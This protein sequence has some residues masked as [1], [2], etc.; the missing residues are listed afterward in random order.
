[1]A[2]DIDGQM[3]VL[4]SSHVIH[5]NQL[6][7]ERN[8]KHSFLGREGQ[9][10]FISIHH[11]K[12]FQIGTE[13]Q[14]VFGPKL[15]A[16]DNTDRNNETRDD[17]ESASTQDDSESDNS[18]DDSESASPQDDSESDNPQDNNES[19]SPRNDRNAEGNHQNKLSYNIDITALK[20]SPAALKTITEPCGCA[21]DQ[22]PIIFKGQDWDLKATEVQKFG[23]ASGVTCGRIVAAQ[24]AYRLPRATQRQFA[25]NNNKIERLKPGFGMLV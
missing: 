25:Q 19:A 9:D 21:F 22:L 16:T 10:N 2:E 14:S 6:E 20:L 1:M 15:F 7:R 13:C 23:A 4:T 8:D 5:H 11:D 24:Y 18:Q 12:V 3:Y 17:S